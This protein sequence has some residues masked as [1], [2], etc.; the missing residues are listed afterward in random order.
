MA[1]LAKFWTKVQLWVAIAGAVGLAVLFAFLRGKS[2]GESAEKAK[3]A[4]AERKASKEV[5]QIKTDVE[6]LSESKVDEELGKWQ[7]RK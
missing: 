6:S 1:I 4:A 3:N 2:I 5:T 7:K